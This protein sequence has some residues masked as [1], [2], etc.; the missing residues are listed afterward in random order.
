MAIFDV[1]A[2]G[3]ERELEACAGSISVVSHDASD[4][5]R[6]YDEPGSDDDHSGEERGDSTIEYER[7]YIDGGMGFVYDGQHGEEYDEGYREGAMDEQCGLYDD[8]SCDEDD[9]KHDG[10]DDGYDD[11]YVDGY[12]DGYDEGCDDRCDVKQ[13]D[14]G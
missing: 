2:Q 1:R 9:F 8:E 13:D 6:E 5:G 12:D 3:R 10:Y 14:H 11:G 7:G 4:G